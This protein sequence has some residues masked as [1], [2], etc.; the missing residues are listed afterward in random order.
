MSDGHKQ[1]KSLRI[2]EEYAAL[3]P[4][5]SISDFETLKISIKQYGQYVP[6]VVNK[7]LVILDGYHRYKVCQ[8]LRITPKITT[9]KFENQLLE[10][11]FIIEIN[12]N[13]RQLTP[14]Q[15]IELEYKYEKIE[16][17]L[18]KTRMS[19]AGKIGAERRWNKEVSGDIDI[20]DRV[21][22]KNNPP[23]GLKLGEKGGVENNNKGKVIELAAQKA[24]VSP[25]TYY[26]GREIIRQSP[27]LEILDKLR[28]GQV[29]VDKVTNSW[30]IDEGSKNCYQILPI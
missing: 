11:K 4:L 15:R 23:S 21:V 27:P 14:F 28:R 7:D 3:V 5:L 10:K 12:R 24:N 20:C 6:I 19:S 13:R 1:S 25:M 8:E 2:V 17:E 26:K 16:S 18:A 29:K 9:R 22:Q 30:K